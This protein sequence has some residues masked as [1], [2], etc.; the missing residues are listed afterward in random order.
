M[1]PGFSEYGT[2]EGNLSVLTER[3]GVHFV[4]YERVWDH[5]VKCTVPENLVES[6][7]EMWRK[8]VAA[9]GMVHYRPDGLPT[10]IEADEIEA[11]PD[12]S[13]LP[14]HESVLGILQDHA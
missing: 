10:R 6:M 8:R 9:H 11:F 5:G 7:M 14:S 3:G 4:I 12:D 1:R 13:E 2:V